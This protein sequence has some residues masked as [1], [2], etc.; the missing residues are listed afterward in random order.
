ME[1]IGL[2]VPDFIPKTF[3]SILSLLES[4]KDNYSWTLS[5]N[6]D[7]FSL[8]IKSEKVKRHVPARCHKVPPRKCTDVKS[9]I[10]DIDSVKQS[11]KIR[12]PVLANRTKHKSPSAI[13]RDKARRKQYRLRKRQLRATDKAE[14]SSGISVSSDLDESNCESECT[15]SVD[16]VHL[17]TV[18][19]SRSTPA[20]LPSSTGEQLHR[21]E[22]VPSHTT[23]TDSDVDSDYSQQ[24]SVQLKTCARC[25][26][27]V[28]TEINCPRCN[29]GSYCSTECQVEDWTV[30]HKFVCKAM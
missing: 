2:A 22:C 17:T 14:P 7:G 20:S 6:T 21:V 30:W 3:T 28:Q 15:A 19:Q 1:N 27:E 10:L 29:L 5:R 16:N 8:T 25:K 9:P 18:E 24:E 23:D 11:T 4:D 26:R 12:A 13:A